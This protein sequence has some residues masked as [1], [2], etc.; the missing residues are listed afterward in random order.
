MYECESNAGALT[1]SARE[2]SLTERRKAS[3]GVSAGLGATRLL[4]I[5]ELSDPFGP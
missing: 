2:S 5:K 4:L 3:W 1:R